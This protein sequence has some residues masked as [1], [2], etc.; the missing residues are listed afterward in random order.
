MLANDPPVDNPHAPKRRRVEV[1]DVQDGDVYVASFPPPAGQWIEREPGKTLFELYRE[2]QKKAGLPP[3]APY[4]SL[5]DWELA[6]WLIKSGVSQSRIDD[7]FKLRKVR[8][9][10]SD[11]PSL[12]D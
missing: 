10:V 2:E 1:E 12:H 6:K 8:T 11:F 4:D 7:F 5:E 3:W 9:L